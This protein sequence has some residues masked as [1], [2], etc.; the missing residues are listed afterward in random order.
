[1]KALLSIL[2]VCSLF[3]ISFQA[4]GKTA[5][6]EQENNLF[7]KPESAVYFQFV[8]DV[9]KPIYPIFI[10]SKKPLESQF[11]V[12]FKRHVLYPEQVNQFIVSETDLDEMIGK[13]NEALQPLKNMPLTY[14]TQEVAVGVMAHGRLIRW[15]LSNNESQPLLDIVQKESVGKYDDLSKAILY[16]RVRLGID[17]TYQEQ[18]VKG[19]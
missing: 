9:L 10:S 18:D 3:L 15:T 19:H 12:V 17:S 4:Y 14:K 8:G 2:F 1:M 11:K 13:I 7:N 16:L 6:V 5:W